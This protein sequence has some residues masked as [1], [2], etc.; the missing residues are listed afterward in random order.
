MA[1]L[2]VIRDVCAVVGV[3]IPQNVFPS[4]VGNRT[5]QE[6]VALANEMAQ[7]IAYDTR[8][9]TAL[10]KTHIIYGDSVWVPPTN[11][12]PVDGYFIP[13]T[14]AWDLPPDF[15][16]LLLKSN[17]WRTSS[18]QQPMVFIPDAEQWLH[19]RARNEAGSAWGEWTIIAGQMHI[20]PALRGITPEVIVI[21]PPYT[22]P[23]IPPDS[24]YF[25]YLDKN[26]INL[27]APNGD[28][29]GPGDTF[30]GDL[31]TFRLSERLLKLG[32]IWQWKA[33][34]GSAY[35]EDMGTYGDALTNEM[36]HDSPA[37]IIVG[38]YRERAYARFY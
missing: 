6:M 5:M 35:A 12:P 27:V 20:Y 38:D 3:A 8:D 16:R 9:W 19:R 13:G 23:A 1:L 25:V 17:V 24:A 18:V 28:A 36:G 31:D 26:C 4:L 15:K 30:Q 29:L 34:K 2:Q 22:V 33:Q 7:R 21:D 11:V 37:P 32:M 10:K 14:T